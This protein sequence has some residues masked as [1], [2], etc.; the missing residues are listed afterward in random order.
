MAAEQHYG[1]ASPEDFAS[2]SGL[3]LLQGL[4]AGTIPAPTIARAMEFRLVEVEKGRAV[5]ESNPSGRLL[6]PMGGVHGGVA[7]TLIDSAA[8]CAV[9]T[10]LEAG[11]GYA[12]V[13]TKVN[14]TR[15]IQPD[16]GTLRAEGRVVTLGRQIA[17]AEAYVTSAAGKVVAHGTSTLIIL[18]PR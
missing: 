12:T 13:E 3:E 5:F 6:N 10:M 17:T 7:L 2:M 11:I 1:V 4:V 16:G 8:G 14:F 9:H 15:P 18:A